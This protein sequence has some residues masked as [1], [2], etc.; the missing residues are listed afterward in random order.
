LRAI[1]ILSSNV[2]GSDSPKPAGPKLED[3]Q[4]ACRDKGVKPGTAAF[5]ECVKRA[6]GG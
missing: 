4:A 3:A 1:R 2:C 6:L 5:M